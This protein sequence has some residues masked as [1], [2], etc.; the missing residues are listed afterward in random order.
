MMVSIFEAL[1]TYNYLNC[2]K[3]C[4]NEWTRCERARESQGERGV[5]GGLRA[6]RCHPILYPGWIQRGRSGR[7][8]GVQ[9]IQRPTR[10]R[11]QLLRTNGNLQSSTFEDL[12]AP[13]QVFSIWHSKICHWFKQLQR[14]SFPT[15][16]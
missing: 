15:Y 5:R 3:N 6:I 11:A 7:E 14:M 10:P 16:C 13:L 4:H 12:M 2:K 8:R 9:N 1:K